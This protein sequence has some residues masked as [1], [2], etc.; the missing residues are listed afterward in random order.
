[1]LKYEKIIDYIHNGI[2]AGN[3]TYKKKLPSIRTISQ[4]FNCCI[5]TVLKAYDK[6]EKDNIVYPYPK[7]GYY[8][9]E[10]FH[11]TNPS[12]NTIIDFSSGVP[13]IESFPY[14]D[15]QHCLNKSIDLYKETLFTYS[16]PRGLNSLTHVLSKHFQQ[17]QV[18]TNSDNIVITSSSQQALT[19]LSIMP[20]PNGKS[21]ILVEQPT[22]YGIIKILELN[23]VSVLGIERGLNGIDLYE[24]ENMFKYDNIKFFYTVPRFHNPTGTSYNKEEKESIVAMAQK[25]N[26]YIVEDDIVSDLDINKKND[27]MFTYDTTEKVIYLKSYSKILMPGL[28]VA[29][30]ILPS[31]L[32]STFLNYKKWTDMNSPIL[33]QGALEIYLKSG[34]FD[35]HRNKMS[36]LYCDRMT[37]LKNTISLL[38]HSKIKWNIPKSG[39]FSCIYVDDS[40]QYDKIISSLLN[41]NI[42]MLDTNLCF[43]EQNRNDHYFRISISNVNEEK[44]KK[45]IPIVI[46]TIQKYMT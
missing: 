3:F 38:Q 41:N 45:G 5:G 39:Y 25:Y 33:S 8:L 24:L 26:V 4:L 46:N 19:I 28:R 30:L 6:L 32:I 13:D 44:I 42:K 11:N 27:P 31:L 2:S 23:N 34:L 20:F 21:N 15:F 18:F 43:L 17:Y 16:N 22:Y 36:T 10:D 35:I 12:N 14:K 37:Y 7:S 40:L 29:A 1:M 9:L